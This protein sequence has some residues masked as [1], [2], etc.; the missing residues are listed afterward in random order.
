MET[1]PWHSEQAD[2]ETYGER[3]G[4]TLPAAPPSGR[5][6][7]PDRLPFS[8]LSDI[9][10]AHVAAIPFDNLDLVL[11]RPV[12]LELEAIT[13]KLCGRPRGGCC[14]EHN[15]LFAAAV[16]RLGYPV[17][18]LAG[19]VLKGGEGP[20]PRTHMAVAVRAEGEV[21][22]C[23]TG[24]GSGGFVTPLP[25]RDG[26]RADQGPRAFRVVVHDP[27]QWRVDERVPGGWSPLYLL[28]REPR[29][30][31]DF[32]VAHHYLTTHPRSMLRHR[33]FVHRL[34]AAGDV[35]LRGHTLTRST[36][37]GPRRTELRP[38]DFE[39]V[40]EREFGIV[41]PDDALR[42]IVDRTFA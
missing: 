11:D 10:R 42:L 35:S 3:L 28:G 41:L 38:G 7:G 20:R 2:L 13:A 26:G 27:F 4:I 21:W 31:V 40:L 18:R 30:P 5:E 23:D 1:S 22:L 32:R 34:T 15:L 17:T 12:S 24:F 25:L 6:P 8:V 14:H 39:G 16:E 19:R 9:H 29:H 33:P 37:A 36:P